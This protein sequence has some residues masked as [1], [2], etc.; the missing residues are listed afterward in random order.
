MMLR[1]LATGLLFVSIALPQ[2]LAHFHHL[3]FHS[4]DPAGAIEFYTTRFNDVKAKLAGDD[5]V[6]TGQWWLLFN[7][8]SQP[9]PHEIIASIYHLGWG[10]R[11]I[12]AA[13]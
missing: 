7:K 12:K 6:W 2:Q 3:H 4:T 1:P 10:S 8:V 13:Y 9:P 11:D 5:A